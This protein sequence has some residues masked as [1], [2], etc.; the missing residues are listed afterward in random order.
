MPSDYSIIPTIYPNYNDLI[1][2]YSILC[3]SLLFMKPIVEF[4]IIIACYP[5]LLMLDSIIGIYLANSV[6]TF[7]DLKKPTEHQLS[8]FYCLYLCWNVLDYSMTFVTT[9]EPTVLP[10][11]LIANLSPSSIAIGVIRLIVIWMLSP[12]ITISV[13]SGS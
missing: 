8:R 4:C 2:F 10:P 11:S 5:Y 12:G 6:N 7:N 3:Q 1:T 13:P 9:P